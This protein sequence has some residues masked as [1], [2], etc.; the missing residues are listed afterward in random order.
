MFRH[1]RQATGA[2]TLSTHDLAVQ[3][4]AELEQKVD[5]GIEAVRAGAVEAK[6]K[7]ETGMLN[8]RS[9]AAH[10]SEPSRNGASEPSWD[11]ESAAAADAAVDAPHDDLASEAFD[12]EAFDEF[13]AGDEAENDGIPQ[14]D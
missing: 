4:L 8:L 7:L 14:P 2:V 10:S 12:L 13:G 3:A 11:L 9:V 6:S 5:A 1:R